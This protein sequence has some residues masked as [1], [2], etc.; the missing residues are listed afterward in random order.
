MLLCPGY[1]AW[2][3]PNETKL[4]PVQWESGPA[5]LKWADLD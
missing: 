1:S 5:T 3:L 4:P 2:A